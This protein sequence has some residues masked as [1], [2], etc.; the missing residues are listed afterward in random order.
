M[1]IVSRGLYIILTMLVIFVLEFTVYS[2]ALNDF[3]IP[4]MIA[5]TYN[6]LGVP[7]IKGF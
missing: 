4:T 7:F 3:Q 6:M 2:F 5:S 1:M